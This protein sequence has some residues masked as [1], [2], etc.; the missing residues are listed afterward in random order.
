MSLSSNGMD[1]LSVYCRHTEGGFTTRCLCHFN[2]YFVVRD[3]KA[4]TLWLKCRVP[5]DGYD[6]FESEVRLNADSSVVIWP[7]TYVK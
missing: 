4:D 2:I 5:N 7:R 6:D 3:V 1:T